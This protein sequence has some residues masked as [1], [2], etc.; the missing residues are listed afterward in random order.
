LGKHIHILPAKAGQQSKN[1]SRLS[2]G[3]HID[4]TFRE[5]ILRSPVVMKQ[6]LWAECNMFSTRDL[7]V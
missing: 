6:T 5:A 3:D 1:K 7:N 2:G 4:Y